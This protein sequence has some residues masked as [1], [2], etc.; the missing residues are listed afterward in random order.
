MSV[1]DSL[2]RMD[3]SSSSRSLPEL[4]S[5]ESSSSFLSVSVSRVL[6]VCPDVLLVVVA[7]DSLPVCDKRRKR[8]SSVVCLRS[9][10]SRVLLMAKS[11]EL[12][13]SRSSTFLSRRALFAP[14]F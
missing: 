9:S 8:R 3:S 12:D 4:S 6:A 7:R 13:I 5:E 14:S 11:D 2:D 1:D 10:R